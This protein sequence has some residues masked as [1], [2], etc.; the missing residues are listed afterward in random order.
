MLRATLVSLFIAA[1]AAFAFAVPASAQDIDC[2]GLTWEEA[3]EILAQDPS[4]PHNLDG[5]NDG[6]A[7]EDN[8]RSG[9]SGG[10]GGS[11][12]GGGEASGGDGTSTGT[13]NASSLPA[14]GTGSAVSTSAAM[15]IFGVLAVLLMV[16]GSIVGRIQKL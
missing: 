2:P 1:M 9:S 13:D 14:T 10:D 5:N 7:C 8:P 11:S 3:Q 15:S 4:D 12:T 6:E 16:G